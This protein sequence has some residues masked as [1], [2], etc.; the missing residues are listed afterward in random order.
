MQFATCQ[1]WPAL[2]SAIS[3][4]QLQ[5]YLWSSDHGQSRDGLTAV[6]FL[7]NYVFEEFAHMLSHLLRVRVSNPSLL[8]RPTLHKIVHLRIDVGNFLAGW[9][10]ISRYSQPPLGDTQ[11]RV[12]CTLIDW[13]EQGVNTTVTV[14]NFP[15][16]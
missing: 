6:N 10:Q 3:Q 9:K 7:M 2:R 12:V 13:E 4:L 1:C 8:H 11:Q 15:S 16:P 5:L 14:K